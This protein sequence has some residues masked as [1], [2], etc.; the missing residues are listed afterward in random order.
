LAASSALRFRPA[1]F[2][3][4]VNIDQTDVT[5]EFIFVSF[6]V[7]LVQNVKNPAARNAISH[8]HE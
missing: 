6:I 7:T 8:S 2:V 5:P 4:V 1:N 3:G